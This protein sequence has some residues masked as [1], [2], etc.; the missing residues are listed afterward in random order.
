MD[1]LTTDFAPLFRSSIGFDRL[2][3]LMD[4][5]NRGDSGGY[6]PY[7][8][9]RTGEDSY[10]ITL[11][12]AGFDALEISITAQANSLV[13]TGKRAEE[14]NGGTFFYRGIAGRSFE[15]RFQLADYIK[16]S[17]ASLKNGLLQV[18]LVREVPE[19]MRPRQIKVETVGEKAAVAQKAAA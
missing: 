10:R 13:V 12:V 3:D 2:V 4:A 6:P 19:A 14:T 7:N 16:V 8:I 5:A 18:E 9:E 15:R 1:M 17:E 11:A